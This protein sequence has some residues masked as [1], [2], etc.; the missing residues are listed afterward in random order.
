MYTPPNTDMGSLVSGE[1]RLRVH[2]V[3]VPTI[4]QPPPGRYHSR[5]EGDG[6][7]GSKPERPSDVS[8]SLNK[9]VQRAAMTGWLCF[10]CKRGEWKEKEDHGGSESRASNHLKISSM[11]S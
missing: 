5:G 4:T 2:V 6:D 11:V 3:I 8:S 10:G 7:G 1:T 9:A